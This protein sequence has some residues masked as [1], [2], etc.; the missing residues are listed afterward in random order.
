[1]SM[2]QKSYYI[3]TPIYYVNDKPHLGH[4]Y[5]SVAC[6]VLARFMRLDGRKVKFLTGTDEHGQKV[7]KSAAAAG[8]PPQ[9]FTNE[10]SEHFRHMASVLGLSNDDFIRTTEARHIKAAQALWQRL[11]AAGDIYLGGYAGWYSVRDEAF[12]QESE[13]VNGKAPTGAEVEWVEEPSYFFKLSNYQDKLLK[14]YNDHP[15]FIL[16]ESRRNEVISFVKGGLK[17][18]SISRTTFKWGIAVPGDEKHIMYV[19]LDALTNYLTAAGFPDMDSADYKT[20]WPANLHMVGK[21]ILRFHAVYWPAFLM[22]A[23]LPVPE[24][25]F[26]H[27]WWTIEGEKMSKSLGNVVA[28]EHLVEKYGLDQTRYFLL[29]E[30]PFGQ[31]GNFS[32]QSMAERINSD[33]A[34][35]IGNLAQ[36]TLSMIAK[37]C[38]GRIPTP[39]HRLQDKAMLEKCQVTKPTSLNDAREQ[40][41]R[42]KFHEVLQAILAMSSAANEFIDREAPWTQKKTDPAAMEATLYTLAEV[43]R[44]IGIMLQPFVPDSADRLLNQLAVSK[45]HRSFED[46][47]PEHALKPGTK[48]PPPEGVFPR[49]MVEAA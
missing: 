45:D 30:V 42:C 22:S 28:P 44:C 18:L 16:P 3:T 13:L 32:R 41:L 20:F 8:M 9:A 47:K 36:R 49:I 37:H 35:N 46:L 25:V 12:Y 1:M 38:D 23:K 43:I 34:N 19:W 4:A 39:Q 40:M 26:A 5:T 33:L 7:E 14:F 48:L 11:E 27:G 6:D 17:D 31:D 15:D 10:V 2:A 29:R 24:R 21:D